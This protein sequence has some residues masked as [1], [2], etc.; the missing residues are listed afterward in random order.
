[1]K[2]FKKFFL[3]IIAVIVFGVIGFAYKIYDFSQPDVLA[4]GE[5][6]EIQGCEMTMY[7]QKKKI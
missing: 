5:T 2:K 3:I 1:M 7:Q 6:F 4:I